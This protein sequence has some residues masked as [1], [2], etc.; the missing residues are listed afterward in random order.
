MHISEAS[1][2]LGSAVGWW[3]TLVSRIRSCVL[4]EYQGNINAVHV[5]VRNVHT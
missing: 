3:L 5:F 1:V 4:R 2:A